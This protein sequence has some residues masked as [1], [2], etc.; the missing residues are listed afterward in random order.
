MKN[1]FFLL[2]LNIAYLSNAFFEFKE[3]SNDKITISFNLDNYE[4]EKKNLGDFINIPGSGS[5]SLIGEPLLPSLSS[6]VKLDKNKSYEINYNVI[7]ESEINNVKIMP[8][9]TFG[10]KVVDYK[11]NQ[12]IYSKDS[13]YPEKNLYVSDRNSMSYGNLP[14]G[15]Y[16]YALNGDDGTIGK[17]AAG[18]LGF[19]VII[20]FLAI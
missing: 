13:Q 20:G 11:K 19:V 7:S 3:Q 5:R 15:N 4:I 6:F 2:L 17:V 16:S 1:I 18:I 10:D 9:Q 8:F 12:V 14:V